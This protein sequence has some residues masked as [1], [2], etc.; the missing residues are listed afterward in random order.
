VLRCRTSREKFVMHKLI[1]FA[2]TPA[3][4]LVGG[5]MFASCVP[6]A[7]AQAQQPLY[8]PAPRV[9]SA[10]P[11]PSVTSPVNEPR[12]A[13]RTHERTF[14]AK[15][16]HHRGRSVVAAQTLPFSWRRYWD[17]RSPC[18]PIWDYPYGSDRWQWWWVE[19]RPWWLLDAGKR[20]A[21]DREI[22]TGFRHQS[23][24]H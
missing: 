17:P 21:N 11:G 6:V 7:H 1:R 2:F 24:W 14:V 18:C 5:Y 10:A 4:L 8:T 9:P 16:V 23:S 12:L 3:Q 13:A 22:P 19:G 20:D 15:T